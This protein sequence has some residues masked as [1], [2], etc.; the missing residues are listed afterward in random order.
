ME[1][2]RGND[3]KL[4]KYTVD[5]KLIE[6]CSKLERQFALRGCAKHGKHLGNTKMSFASNSKNPKLEEAC[7]IF[8]EFARL[9]RYH[10]E[11]NCEVR[12][13]HFDFNEQ[14]NNYYVICDL[15][16]NYDW[17]TY[18]LYT[19]MTYNRWCQMMNIIETNNSSKI[20]EIVQSTPSVNNKHARELETT[21]I[22]SKHRRVD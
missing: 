19:T 7:E 20:G 4:I 10:F 6:I 15:N 2:D 13:P 14:Y 11:D 17:A 5:P 8:R 3:V 21:I 1:I 16:Y 18:T 22:K 12:N 9:Y